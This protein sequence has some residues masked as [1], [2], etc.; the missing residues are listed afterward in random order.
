MLDKKACRDSAFTC[1]GYTA[2]FLFISD[3]ILSIRSRERICVRQ[4][5]QK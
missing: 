4:K 2:D 3:Y 5:L 1:V